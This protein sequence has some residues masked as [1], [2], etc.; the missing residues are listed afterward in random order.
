MN[1]IT[2]T[3]RKTGLSRSEYIRKQLLKKHIII[4][5]EIVADISEIN[6]LTSEIGKIGNNL[7]QIAKYF[8]TGGIQ[9]KAM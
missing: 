3:A 8:H 5:Y 7:N 2:S 4:K 9:S 6:R 1:L